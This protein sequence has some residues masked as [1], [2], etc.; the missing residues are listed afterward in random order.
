TAA[1]AVV[2]HLVLRQARRLGLVVDQR[3]VGVQR[4]GH[5]VA[6]DVHQPLKHRLHID[7]LLGRCLEKLQTWQLTERSGLI[8]ELLAAVCADHPL[9]LQ[10]TLVAHQHHLGV[11]PRV[12]LDL[13]HPPV[14]HGLERLLVGDVVHQQEAHGAA[15][16]RSGDGPIPLLTRETHPDLQFDPLV[17][18]EHGL[19]LEVDAD[20][21]DKGRRER[22]VCV[23]E[24]EG[25]LAHT[26]V[27][28]DEQ[29]EHV[30]EVLVR[31]V[32]LPFGV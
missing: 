13:E 23:A 3:G 11:V 7:V 15:V 20:R 26:T 32:L 17:L 5:L 28:D 16:V 24:Q 2:G 27:A 19:D 8:G 25:R 10:V 18:A 1:A 31:G 14:L 6:D 22:V 12:R 21:A 4:L 9:V 30:V 29:L